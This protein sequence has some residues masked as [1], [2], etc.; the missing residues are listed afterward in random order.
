MFESF[1]DRGTR[2]H[3]A[4]QRRR[5]AIK[6]FDNGLLSALF[7]PLVL[8]LPVDVQFQ[9]VS[10]RLKFVGLSL[11]FDDAEIRDSRRYS[12]LAG[13]I[14]LRRREYAAFTDLQ[15][16]AGVNRA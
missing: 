11:G 14:A 8:V 5:V 1:D 16:C 7:C 12:K 13:R 10:G 3:L 6:V 2:S 15:R 9:R 4:F